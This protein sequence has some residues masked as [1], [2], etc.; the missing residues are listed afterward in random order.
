MPMKVPHL[1][2]ESM[3]R[4]LGPFGVGESPELFEQ[5]RV[6]IDTLL[7][8]NARIALTTIT[9]PREILRVHFGESFFTAHAAKI[10]GGRVADIGTGPG[11]PG[12]PI[13]MVRTSIDL[14]LVDPITK[15]TAFL[16]E[17]VRKI[18]L[19]SV[20]IIRCRMEEMER[21]DS[22][23]DF[24]TT[25]ALGH[26]KEFLKWSKTRLSQKGRVVLLVG[27]NDSAELRQARDYSWEDEVAVPK[28]K[29]RVIL[30]GA[31]L[32]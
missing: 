3:E 9:D 5:I 32:R 28:S 24:I 29:S 8:W 26:H 17:V 18:G 7:Y 13:R 1:T 11:F 25:R 12:I 19:N 23:F 16:A 6:Y 22:D 20:R 21:S 4:A 31:P 2:D 10:E 30:I 15:K 27:K 14:T